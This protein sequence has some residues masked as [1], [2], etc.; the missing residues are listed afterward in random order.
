MIEEVPTEIKWRPTK[1]QEDFLSLPDSVFEALYGGAA[2]GGKSEL[3]LYIPIVR[4]FYKHPRFKGV[5]FRETYPQLEASLILRA[6]EIYPHFGARYNDQKHTYTFP[7]GATVRF[8]Y[9]ENDLQARDHD[10]NEYNYE[11]WDELTAFSEFRYRYL[12]SRCRSSNANLPAIMRGATN[13]G[14]IGHV[15][16]RDRF[17]APCVSGYKILEEKIKVKDSLTGIFDWTTISK[18]IFI[19][20]KLTDNPHILE[21]D[22]QYINRLRMLPLADQKAKIDGDWFVFAGQV[23]KEFRDVKF[24][25]EP[26]N[27]IHVIEPFEIPS[28]WPR[29][30]AID[31]GFKADTIALKGACSPDGRLFIYYEYVANEKNVSYWA[32]DIARESQHEVLED[33]DLD[34]SAWQDRGQPE[35]IAQQFEKYSK[36]RPNQAENDRIGGKMLIHDFLRWSEK[37]KRYVPPGGYAQETHDRILRLRGID[38]ATDYINSF[39][40]EPPETNIPI[41]QIF[42]TCPNLIS[43]IPLCIY[44]EKHPEDV[45]GWAP[46]YFEGEDSRT[47]GDDAYDCLRYLCKMFSRYLKKSVDKFKEI[48]E[49]EKISKVFETDINSAYR[50]MEIHEKNTR[51]SEVVQRYSRRYH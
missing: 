27:A 51:G 20:S 17:V 49:I 45:K 25:D 16:V 11:G 37:P 7:S 26:A 5:L 46:K 47:P 3:L 15:W 21:N 39:A 41:L 31:W 8:S 12:S 38:A 6:R 18:R 4:E 32:S 19:P 50:M 34:P 23:F 35:T 28:Y 33:I 48:K 24:P 44:D 9:L 36:L 40:P 43:V 30:M 2:G 14:N 42:N 22:P 13:P 29:F 1:R 10:T